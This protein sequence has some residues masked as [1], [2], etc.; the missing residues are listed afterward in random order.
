MKSSFHHKSYS[1]LVYIHLV[2]ILFVKEKCRNDFFD[3]IPFRSH[4]RIPTL[5]PSQGNFNSQ[6]FPFSSL[7]VLSIRSFKLVMNYDYLEE[8]Y[9]T[10]VTEVYICIS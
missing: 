5:I 8:S 9:N 4:G 7:H 10:S 6:S 1:L 2:F 3:R